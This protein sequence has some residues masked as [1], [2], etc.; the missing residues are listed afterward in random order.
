M[1]FKYYIKAKKQENNKLVY[2]CLHKINEK[3]LFSSN[4]YG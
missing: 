4:K 3:F 2:S 1:S